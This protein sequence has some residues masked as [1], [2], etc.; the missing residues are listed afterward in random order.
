MSFVAAEFNSGVSPATVELNAW[1]GSD[2]ATTPAA[3]R[4][5]VRMND[6]MIETSMVVSVDT[7]YLLL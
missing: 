6:F 4:S 2:K 7:D 3:P 1:A 5:A